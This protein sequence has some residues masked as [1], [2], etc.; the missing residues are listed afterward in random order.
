MIKNV[1]L[2]QIEPDTFVF[3]L[4]LQFRATST[5]QTFFEW[6]ETE[7]SA[8]GHFKRNAK[9]FGANLIL[10]KYITTEDLQG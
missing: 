1:F 9:I 4:S 2:H 10:P 3:S 6:K 5:D 8:K 7:N